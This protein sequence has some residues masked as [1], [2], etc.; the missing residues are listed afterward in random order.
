MLL[1]I[2]FV[3]YPRVHP[4]ISLILLFGCLSVMLDSLSARNH[5]VL[6]LLGGRGEQHYGVYHGAH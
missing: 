3:L 4:S 2:A 5:Q 6:Q 1:G